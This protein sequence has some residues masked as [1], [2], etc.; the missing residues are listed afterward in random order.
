MI[1]VDIETTPSAVIKGCGEGIIGGAQNTR[2]GVLKGFAVFV[3][4]PVT[5]RC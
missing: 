3:S 5:D 2:F 4:F 1:N